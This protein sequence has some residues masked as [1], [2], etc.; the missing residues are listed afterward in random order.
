MSGAF[1][2]LRG[3]C[4]SCSGLDASEKVDVHRRV[5][6]L[7]GSVSYNLTTS[8]TQVVMKEANLFCQKY[9]VSAKVGIPVVSLDF[10]SEC[11]LEAM[12]RGD[13]SN[14]V[15]CTVAEA[16]HQITA[17]NRFLPFAGCRISSTGL[18]S[19]LRAEIE[20]LVEN[21]CLASTS[22]LAKHMEDGL[23]SRAGRGGGLIGGGGLYC[24]VLTGDCTHLIALGSEGEK[25]KFAKDRSI[26]VVTLEWFVQ[27]LGAGARQQ[28]NDYAVGYADQPSRSTTNVTIAGN[29]RRLQSLGQTEKSTKRIDDLA[30]S[31]R[32]HGAHALAPGF[33]RTVSAASDQSAV[34][35]TREY[36]SGCALPHQGGSVVSRGLT[37]N[38]TANG[39]LHADS[40]D[41]P[42]G[43]SGPLL[44][45]SEEESDVV[46]VEQPALPTH[47]SALATKHP[48]PRP[49]PSNSVIRVFESCHIA[50]SLASLSSARR[51]E[52]RA[53]IVAGGGIC[54]GENDSTDLLAF[55]IAPGMQH[56]RRCTHFVVDDSDELCA[57]DIRTL[58]SAQETATRASRPTRAKANVLGSGDGSALPGRPVVV[59]CRWL[60]D[61]WR[62]GRHIGETPY[63]VAWPELVTDNSLVNGLGD[64]VELCKA[65]PLAVCGNAF[66]SA[67]LPPR[68]RLGQNA[69]TAFTKHQHSSLSLVG[70]PMGC[71]A[72]SNDEFD[73]IGNNSAGYP[74]KRAICLAEMDSEQT[75]SA[76]SKQPRLQSKELAP[77]R[78][79]TR[80]AALAT[81]P[82]AALSSPRLA[83]DVSSFHNIEVGCGNGA[84]ADKGI[85]AQCVFSSL[86][87]TSQAA[88]TLDQVV[89]ENGGSCVV[90]QD[91][92]TRLEH[93]LMALAG[94]FD[95]ALIMDVYILIQLRDTD[96]LATCE[97]AI[98]L[99]PFMHIVTE[100]WV[101][102]CIQD[103]VR[104]PDYVAI[105]ALRLPYP[106]LG[107]GQ[108][109]LFR[110]LSSHQIAGASSVSLSI[111]GYE[112]IERD[113][114]GKLTQA[115]GIA[116]SET[117]S[118]RTTHLICHPPFKG[119]KYERALKWGVCVVDSSWLYGVVAAGRVGEHK[120]GEGYLMA[121][122]EQAPESHTHDHG[123]MAAP[124]AVTCASK[125]VH[126]PATRSTQ[127]LVSDTPGRT[128]MDISLERNL[129]QALG[130]NR[131]CRRPAHCGDE[132]DGGGDSDATQMSPTHGHNFGRGVAS[133]PP[134]ADGG[135]GNGTTSVLSGVVAVL[136]SRLYH[137]RNELTALALQL[138]CRVL[139][140]FDSKQTT[141]FIHQSNRERETLR[142]YRLALQHGVRI[143]SPWWLYAC[144]DMMALAPED[145]FPY[146]Y[147][148]ERRLLLSSTLPA[149]PAQQ[150]ADKLDSS[151]SSI[152]RHLESR[153]N[154]QLSSAHAS[155]GHVLESTTRLIDST[156]TVP[157]SAQGADSAA[158]VDA[159]EIDSLLG[160]KAASTRRKYRQSSPSRTGHETIDILTTKQH[161]GGDLQ[162][163]SSTV[164]QSE[165]AQGL[166]QH[167]SD[168]SASKGETRL[169]GR[170]PSTNACQ[171]PQHWR[172]DSQ[173]PE[174]WWLDVDSVVA[175]AGGGA[176][177][178]ASLYSQEH[179]PTGYQGLDSMPST[180]VP[181]GLPNTS[182]VSTDDA[183][184]HTTSRLDSRQA[185][186]KGGLHFNGD[187]PCE[188]S[189]KQGISL[190]ANAP[191]ATTL[192][193]PLA[194]HKTTIVYGE[195]SEAL[196][197][198]DRLIQR[199]IGK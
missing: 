77:G 174:K 94:K 72:V 74:K 65:E 122:P 39:S 21:T 104:Y 156:R 95:G 188:P 89:R 135:D 20:R 42:P 172:A 98:C 17:R 34:P 154:G 55:E 9:Y 63:I 40:L 144:R 91:P 146:T 169:V 99:P 93:E 56:A 22:L 82:T 194:A 92:K 4:I 116:Y 171:A 83:Q 61:C 52:W 108:H 64:G 137:R 88:A 112:G 187:G 6:Q 8:V 67:A 70:Q 134:S 2:L 136:S 150:S 185:S 38:C 125:H 139:L 132:S 152:N 178:Q 142:D 47:A 58:C 186:A 124:S 11:E 62:T 119:Q 190:E 192:S 87:L 140:R 106:G 37:R 43:L 7:G 163:S 110:P 176:E 41:L 51:N 49:L 161:A 162:L 177:Y 86:G 54:I 166:R 12:E 59:Q 159:H 23:S 168:I 115:L 183:D 57:E 68:P 153:S 5:V 117:F 28:E 96:L 107:P 164:K 32:R 133:V 25:F 3:F 148:P 165:Y 111:S 10:V 184:W 46:L 100:C 1:P 15:E 143:V 24:G 199:L 48:P 78:A 175:G 114:I 76:V 27:S 149:L 31:P 145:Q 113:H 158:A 105:Q 14:T 50:L 13:N 44:V 109:V 126:T 90:M 97:A 103:E 182:G 69:L 196:S 173:T 160:M 75:R 80:R 189:A 60:R 33:E 197:E 53:K 198:R 16:V 147:D 45:D 102:Q 193:S 131:A 180:N 79:F 81:P 167:S 84:G 191:A 18:Q 181:Y 151:T 73:L 30:S 123:K 127:R 195:D 118:R 29:M 101:E 66:E 138:G 35:P 71:S 120:V 130:N 26:P 155:H 19:E 121:S 36:S 157:L 179:P 129:Q 128:P 141:H 85:F 170:G